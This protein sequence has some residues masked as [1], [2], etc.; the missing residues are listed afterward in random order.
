MTTE[1]FTVTPDDFVFEAVRL[2]GDRQVRR[3]LANKDDALAA[4][5]QAGLDLAPGVDL[6]NTTP[7]HLAR[8]NRPHVAYVLRRD[9][10]QSRLAD[11]VAGADL[12]GEPAGTG[13]RVR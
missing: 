12:G 7:E 6:K 1:L 2:M 9:A 10:G 8:T 3:R 4:F 5:R 13:E 11:V